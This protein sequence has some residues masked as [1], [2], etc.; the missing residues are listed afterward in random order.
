MCYHYL[1]SNKIK[2][3]LYW[4]NNMS[5]GKGSLY[6]GDNGLTIYLAHY[7]ETYYNEVIVPL[8]PFV[9]S[10]KNF[11][12]AKY[13]GELCCGLLG[14][15]GLN[16]FEFNKAYELTMQACN[17]N[18]DLAMYKEKLDKLFKEDPRFQEVKK[19]A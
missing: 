3:Y 5:H 1:T 7:L 6:I 15:R 14:I 2:L 13:Y 10:D 18:K 9:T 11:L 8:A 16:E 4:E 19:V 17:R 12:D